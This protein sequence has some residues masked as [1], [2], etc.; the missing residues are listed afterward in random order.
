MSSIYEAVPLDRDISSTNIRV[1][2]NLV[3]DVEGRISCKLRTISLEWKDDERRSQRP[4]SYVAL[5]YTWG[6]PN[7]GKSISIDGKPF[8]VRDN[9][10]DFLHEACAHRAFACDTNLI[11]E[12]WRNII[13]GTNTPEEEQAYLWIDAICIDQS[14]VEERNHQVAMMGKIYSRAQKVLVWLGRPTPLIAEL[15]HDMHSL[16]VDENHKLVWKAMD[17]HEWERKR[18]GLE[19]LCKFE[20][21][22]R[23]WVVQEYILAK[24]V[25]ICCGADSVDPQ[26]ISWLVFPVFK[27]R[28][29]GESC[30]LQLMNGRCVRDANDKPVSLKKHLND[31]GISMKCADVR[32]RVYGMLALIDEKEREDLGLRPDYALS[33]LGL[34]LN[35]ISALRESGSYEP[36]ELLDYVETLH[37][38]LELTLDDVELTIRQALGHHLY[39][40][41]VARRNQSA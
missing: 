4:E 20:Y 11:G 34:F 29:L 6:P 12:N 27:I 9:L 33:P 13:P 22:E 3:R 21:W 7:V 32:D 25:K 38:A 1:I 5:S 37:L 17:D 39:N 41:W 19:E 8:E 10:W 24:D 16:K 15:L 31:F 23:L 26:K 35:L 18:L 14:Q 2:E 40:E 36:D 28:Y 30:A